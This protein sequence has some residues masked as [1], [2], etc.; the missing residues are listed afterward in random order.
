MSAQ[1]RPGLS[2]RRHPVAFPRHGDLAGR[3]TKAGALT[4][5]T[6]G[7]GRHPAGGL[8]RSTKAG[9]L[10]PATR[11]RRGPGRTARPSLNEG[12]GS[13]PGDTTSYRNNSQNQ[14]DAQRR[15]GSHPGDTL[16]HSEALGEGLRR[17]TKAGALTPATPGRR[18]PEDSGSIR[19]TKAGAL[20][21]ATRGGQ[22]LGAPLRRLP[23]NEGRGSHPGDTRENQAAPGR[24]TRA[25]N[26]GRGSHP[27]DTRR[28]GSVSRISPSLNEGR[29]SHP[30]DTHPKVRGQVEPPDRS[31]KAGALT[32]ATRDLVV[33]DLGAGHGRSTKAG[34]LTPATRP[35]PYG[36]WGRPGP[37]NEG[38][39]SHPGDTS[40]TIRH[41]E[42]LH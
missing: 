5:A 33:L 13:H 18:H 32:P 21:P 25:L 28:P 4:P 9:A 1:R 6:R 40:P 42:S 22:D 20:T 2:P 14:I 30:G 24:Q 41:S 29:G 27:G 34:A 26:E 31:T 12:R 39:G 10:T 3:S 35:N 19:S 16:H 36:W 37:L 15:P 8:R 17:S 23:L 11:P 38:R 7:D